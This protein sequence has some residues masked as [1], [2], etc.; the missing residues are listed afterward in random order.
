MPKQ[1][2]SDSVQFWL[3]RLEIFKPLAYRNFRLLW[4][5]SLISMVGAQLTL[6]AFPW[7]VLKISGGA[8]AV[9]LVMALSGI[10]RALFMLVGGVFTDRFSPRTVMIWSTWLRLILMTVLTLL[11]FSGWV[12]LW[13]L[14]VVALVF[15]LI[16]AFFWPAS[17]ALVPRLIPEKVLHAGNGLIQGTGQLS[18]MIGPLV[19]GL[20]I[21]L[22][23]VA[24]AGEEAELTGI[25][26]VFAIDSIGF[27]FSLVTLW[28]ISM[29]L[30]SNSAG[31]FTLGSALDSMME[32]FRGLWSDVSVRWMSIALAIFSLLWKG[33][34]LVGVP[35]LCDTRFEDGALAFGL[36]TSSFGVGALLG[37]TL[38]ASLPRPASKWYGVLFLIDFCVLGVGLIVYAVTPTVVWAVVATAVAGLVDGYIIILLIS[39]LQIR[40]PKEMLGRTMSVII[41]CSVGLVPVSASVTGFLIGISLSGVF[42]A[43]GGLLVALS[44]LGAFHPVFRNFD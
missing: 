17:S 3:Y 15:G 16:D 20:I 29:E 12:N 35:V 41:F 30:E 32:G 24:G 10:P 8:M 14:Y 6:I 11:V 33:P 25:G 13:I 38:A 18:V 28:L 31:H 27:L 34:Y 1:T 37:L 23:P 26:M 42:L 39:W 44:L 5:G 40:I 21:S 9:G 22:F 7:L 19:A 43:M 2:E 4:I 36:I